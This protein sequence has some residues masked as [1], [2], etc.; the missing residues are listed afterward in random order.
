MAGFGDGFARMR[1]VRTARKEGAVDQSVRC[2]RIN[3]TDH[4]YVTSGNCG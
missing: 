3:R 2:E 4:F 1:K